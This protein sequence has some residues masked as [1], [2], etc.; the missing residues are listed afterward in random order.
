MDILSYAK[1]SRSKQII[2]KLIKDLG[3]GAAY[4]NGTLDVKDNYANVK[5]RLDALDTLRQGL[6][7]KEKALNEQDLFEGL[8]N[9]T[10]IVNKELTLSRDF[11]KVGSIIN[12]TMTSNTAPKNE[13][14]AS[15]NET[16]AW[17]AFTNNANSYFEA[18]TLDPVSL[19]YVF[20]DAICVTSYYTF[21]GS[22]LLAGATNYELKASND[23]EVFVTLHR[24]TNLAR[25]S[26]GAS[27]QFNILNSES[28]RYYQLE[29][30]G[31]AHGSKISIGQILFTESGFVDNG[32]WTSEEFS[33]EDFVDYNSIQIEGENI[34]STHLKIYTKTDSDKD[35]IEVINGKVLSKK[36]KRI[37]IKL[38]LIQ[39]QGVF[40]KIKQ[41][42]LLYNFVTII[43]RVSEIEEATAVNINKYNLKVA[44]LLN[45]ER[46]RLKNLIVDD[47]L[48]GEGIDFERSWN[49]SI[50]N[51]NVGTTN[52]NSSG[53]LIT[54]VE[55]LESPIKNIMVSI[56][57]NKLYESSPDIFYSNDDGVNWHQINE[58]ECVRVNES[59]INQLRI[60]VTLRPGEE[61]DGISYSWV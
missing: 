4:K 18:N 30:S 50:K 7:V 46:Y 32:E 40:P 6:L 60:R 61:I 43:G 8:K 26:P 47:F 56:V 11:S 54:K 29:V 19:T 38:K 25:L 33:I 24:V 36:N 39:V 45:A 16:E 59:R 35:F 15:H 55:N 31:S 52:S 37:K 12:T 3:Y 22:E 13:V 14:Y 5:A 44:A 51:R 49:I 27:R 1:S 2:N 17:K 10:D 58:D 42:K 21:G 57:R 28:Y 9:K 34:S 23:G 53:E 48:T 41:I 20:E